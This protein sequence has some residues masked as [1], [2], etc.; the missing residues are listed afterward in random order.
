MKT[1]INRVLIFIVTMLSANI[2]YA[3]APSAYAT[4]SNGTTYGNL[5]T[6]ITGKRRPHDGTINDTVPPIVE[7]SNTVRRK[8]HLLYYETDCHPVC[9]SSSLATPIEM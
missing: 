8:N 3:S 9:T 2:I 6:F 5:Q 4:N 7:G 1:K